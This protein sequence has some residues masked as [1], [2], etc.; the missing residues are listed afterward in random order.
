MFQQK[1]L[2]LQSTSFVASANANAERNI[3]GNSTCTRTKV[4]SLPTSDIR[5]EL[6]CAKCSLQFGNKSVFDLH[7]S[8]VNRQMHTT[9]F[10]TK[11]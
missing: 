6:F 9:I 11:M 10:E 2:S 3:E 8:I 5:Q 1:L 7:V 4:E